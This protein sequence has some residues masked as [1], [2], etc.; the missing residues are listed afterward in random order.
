V[1]QA[2]QVAYRVVAV[3]AVDVVHLCG[4]RDLSALSAVAAQWFVL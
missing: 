4:W 3:V 1:A 2:L